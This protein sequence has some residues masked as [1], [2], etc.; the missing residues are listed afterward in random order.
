MPA[1]SGDRPAQHNASPHTPTAQPRAARGPGD[2]MPSPGRQAAGHGARAPARV[3]TR[4]WPGGQR[5]RRRRRTSWHPSRCRHRPVLPAVKRSCSP[6]GALTP[7]HR[8]HPP[9]AP[10]GTPSKAP[11]PNTPTA[12]ARRSTH[13]GRQ[14]D[15]RGGRVVAA[16]HRRVAGT[17]PP[18][19]EAAQ[20]HRPRGTRRE[21]PRLSCGDA[22][23]RRMRRPGADRAAPYVAVLPPPLPPVRPSHGPSLDLRSF[24]RSPPDRIGCPITGTA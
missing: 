20:R 14:E 10:A 16:P 15:S 22:V 4:G 19:Q 8:L 17:A 18:R 21:E 24:Y 3:G 9:A 5:R 6:L 2:A 23:H 13:Q 11:T 12:A 1:L 7:R